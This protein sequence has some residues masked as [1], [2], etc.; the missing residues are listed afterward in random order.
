MIAPYFARKPFFRQRENV[1]ATRYTP[2]KHLGPFSGYR[3]GNNS[4]RVAGIVGGLQWHD[5]NKDERVVVGKAIGD[6]L[7]VLRSE[8]Q[9]ESSEDC[10]WCRY[11][12][13]RYDNLANAR[14][15]TI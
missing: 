7:P 3:F 9:P 14:K 6:M 15:T 11:V 4:P 1:L 8:R 12:K 13:L 10:E 2:I 5:V